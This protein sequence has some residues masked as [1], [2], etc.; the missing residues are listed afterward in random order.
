[1]NTA[2]TKLFALLF[3]NA[4]KIISYRV[5]Q[6]FKLKNDKKLVDPTVD[7][8]WIKEKAEKLNMI[9]APEKTT[10]EVPVTCPEFIKPEII[11]VTNAIGSKRSKH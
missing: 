10:K 2:S 11:N 5:L 8:R 1:M 6:Y 4:W 7:K 9:L 3:F